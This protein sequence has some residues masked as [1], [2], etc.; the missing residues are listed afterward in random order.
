MA[1]MVDSVFTIHCEMTPERQRILD[2]IGK[3][4]FY[5]H[6]LPLPKEFRRIGFSPRLVEFERLLKSNTEVGIN[7]FSKE[8]LEM[9]D[10]MRY[11]KETF[12]FYTESEYFYDKWGCVGDIV[13]YY[14]SETLTI[15]VETKWVPIKGSVLDMF[16]EDFPSHYYE[17]NEETGW[18]GEEMYVNGELEYCSE[19]DAPEYEEI[20][21]DDDYIC[22]L[23]SPYRD[24]K[25]G[26]YRDSTFE[27]FLGETENKAIYNLY[28]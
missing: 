27:E 22:H 19:W 12:G 15:N 26:Y 20:E 16:T 8:E 18:G 10:N 11:N 14:D 3:V 24:K 23:T 4:G 7:H 2:H 25:I 17:Y 9:L 1:N 13:T 6:Y 5:E 21:V 28:K